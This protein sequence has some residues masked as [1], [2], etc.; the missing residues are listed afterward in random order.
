M[1]KSV[2]A[3]RVALDAWRGDLLDITP[4]KDIERHFQC[5]M[6]IVLDD[7]DEELDCIRVGERMVDLV[8]AVLGFHRENGICGEQP[9]QARLW[10][11]LVS[12]RKP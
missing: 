6:N 3:R 12:N 2:M 7:D 8:E 10:F 4:M 5:H 11:S 1:K 9:T